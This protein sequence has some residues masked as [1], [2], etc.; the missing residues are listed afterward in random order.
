M[1]ATYRTESL[2]KNRNLMTIILGARC[3]DGVVLV[4]DRKMTNKNEYEI[5]Y[6]FDD[7]ITGELNGVLTG[8]SGDRGAFETFRHKLRDR[9]TDMVKQEIKDVI[10]TKIVF[11]NFGFSIDKIRGIIYEVQNRLFRDHRD[12]EY[13]ILVGFSSN[14]TQDKKSVLFHSFPDGLSNPINEVN[15]IGTGAPYSS[16]F[17][18]RYWDK[19][20]RMTEFAQLADLIIRFIDNDRYKLNDGIG[21]N[22]ENPYPQ[23]RYIPDDHDYCMPYNDDKPKPD[24]SP[25]LSELKDFKFESEKML[26]IIRRLP[27]PMSRS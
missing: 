1:N 25:S 8:F 26:D 2:P 5:T 27:F 18:R 21:L 14:Y 19:N 16:Y 20:M 17:I 23:V 24:C 10:Q 9:V 22:P 11:Q 15:V 4:G 12:Y 13:E 6:L 3:Q 7:K